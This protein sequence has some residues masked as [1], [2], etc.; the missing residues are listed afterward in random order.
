MWPFGS[1]ETRVRPQPIQARPQPLPP[2]AETAAEHAGDN[3]AM[4]VVLNWLNQELIKIPLNRD[5]I[6]IGKEHVVS[7]D[8]SK[9][10]FEAGNKIGVV[11]NSPQMDFVSK[12]HCVLIWSEEKR[13]YVIN[14]MSSRGIWVSTDGLPRNAKQIKWDRVCSNNTAVILGEGYSAR[15]Q[16][17]FYIRIWSK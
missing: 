7:Q 6:L 17:P 13:K 16:I 9:Y 3:R 1:K 12:E 15:P 2:V 14:D 11:E 10:V 4:L 5:S 8:P